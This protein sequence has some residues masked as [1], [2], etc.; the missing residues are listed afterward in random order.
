MKQ[1]W[2][3]N[4]RWPDAAAAIWH[5]RYEQN[6]KSAV[7]QQTPRDVVYVYEFAS[8]WRHMLHRLL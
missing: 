4:I 1:S 5:A 2:L 6:Y 8:R 7:S 3:E